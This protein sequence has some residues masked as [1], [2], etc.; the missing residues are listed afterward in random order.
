M[1]PYRPPF[2]KQLDGSKYAGLNCTMAS[3]AMAAI[4]HQKGVNPP[5]TALWWP[6]PY[7]LRAKTGDTSGG[8]TLAQADSVLLRYYDINLDVEYNL[9]WGTFR[10]RVMKGAGAIIQGGYSTIYQTKYSG[11][12]T[13]SG[14][15][16]VYVNEVRWNEVADRWE[17]LWYDPLCDGRRTGIPKG[18]QWLPEALV[19]KFCE[20]LMLTGT[21]RIAAGKVW[22]AFTRDTEAVILNWGGALYGPKTFYA[23][24][25]NIRIRRT[26]RLDGLV[27][28]TLDK[29]DAFRAFQRKTDGPSVD[30]STVWYGDADG[31]RWTA[32][33]NL[34]STA[35]TG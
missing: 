19:K 16:A 25:G 11:S 4:R 9:D 34:T 28:Q 14:N 30:G 22:C 15:H 1:P 13:F 26:P 23:R 17:Y 21:L 8:T 35:P 7:D 27:V 32:S 33:K 2:I 3:S 20:A 6:R 12:S 10:E 29:G 24:Y 18:P 5:G 31:I